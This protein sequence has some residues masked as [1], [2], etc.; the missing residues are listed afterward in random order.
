MVSL[1]VLC[2]VSPFLLAGA[3]RGNPWYGGG[4][5]PQFYDH[6]CPQAKEIVHSIVAQAV[7]RETRM[8]ASLVRLHFH[9]CFVKVESASCWLHC[10]FACTILPANFILTISYA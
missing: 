4:L 1:V 7:A 5:F 8:A 6:S 3:V 10:F 2:L 9:D